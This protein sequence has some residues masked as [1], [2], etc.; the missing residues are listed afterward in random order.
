MYL[1]LLVKILL[2][3]LHFLIIDNKPR[4]LWSLYYN[5]SLSSCSHPTETGTNS[6]VTSDLPHNVLM[7]SD[8]DDTISYEA[9]I[10]EVHCTLYIIL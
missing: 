2:I 5:L 4:L 9:C 8:P 10:H 3:L 7:V 1:K 6:D